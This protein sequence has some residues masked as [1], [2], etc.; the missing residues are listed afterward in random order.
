M[1][2]IYLSKLTPEAR[3]EL[4][5]DLLV[6]QSGNCFICGREIDLALQ[7]DHIDIDH[8]EPLKI[9]GKDGPDNFAAT[10]DSC[11]RAKQASDL[12]VARVLA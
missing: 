10:H 4:V 8:V 5:K 9:G 2:S 6:S 1:G 12:R 3:Q 11:N 7:V